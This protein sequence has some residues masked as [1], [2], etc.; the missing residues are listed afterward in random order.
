MEKKEDNLMTVDELADYLR[1]Q[2][3]MIYSFIKS[4]Y[5]PVYRISGQWRFR[6]SEIEKWLEQQ[7]YCGD[8]S[9]KE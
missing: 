6:E 5:V 4:G 7:I 9:A 2:K 8:A 1:F 3:N